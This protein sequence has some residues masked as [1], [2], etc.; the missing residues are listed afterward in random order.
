MHYFASLVALLNSLNDFVHDELNLTLGQFIFPFVHISQQV[1]LHHFGDNVYVILIIIQVNEFYHCIAAGV[2]QIP[3]HLGFMVYHL[4]IDP[5]HSSLI[6][7]LN[8]HF[9]PGLPVDTLPNHGILASAKIIADDIILLQ[10][11]FVVLF[12]AL[13]FLHR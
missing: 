4:R 9:F 12:K 1:H 3:Q 7:Y 6:E 10:I 13:E 8:C 11:F 5:R 2:S